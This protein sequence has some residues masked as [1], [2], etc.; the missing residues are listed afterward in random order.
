MSH[1][2]LTSE[3]KLAFREKGYLLLQGALNKSQVEPIK[4][5]VLNELKRLKIWSSGK[6]LSA[7]IKRLPAFQ[8]INKLSGLIKLDNLHTRLIN[9]E[10]LDLIQS[11]AEIKLVPA[12]S[13]FLISLPDQGGWTINGL[14]WHTDISSAGRYLI[15]GIQAFVLIDDVK[16]HGGATLAIAG[17]HLVTGHEEASRKVREILRRGDDYESALRSRNMSIIE[18]SGQAGDLYLMNMGLLHTPSFNSTNRVRMMAT[19]RYLP[20]GTRAA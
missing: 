18:M 14:N 15:P 10:V 4:A 11:L 5:Y 16:P 2:L 9:Q 20:D 3:Q 6:T 13:Q 7:P 19:V 1:Y 17:S 8:Q 12:Q